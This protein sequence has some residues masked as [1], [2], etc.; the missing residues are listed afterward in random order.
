M[1]ARPSRRAV[2]LAF[3]MQHPAAVS[4]QRCFARSSGV[5]E[6]FPPLSGKPAPKRDQRQPDSQHNR[7]D[8]K[9]PA[10][11]LRFRRVGE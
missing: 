11:A 2:A 6:Y 3:A 7:T 10:E 9:P 8:F 5:L 4:A 1:S